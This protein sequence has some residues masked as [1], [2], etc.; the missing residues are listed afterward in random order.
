M[1]LGI[2]PAPVRKS[3]RIKAG[4]QKAFDVFTAGMGRWWPPSHSLLKAPR[5]DVVIEPR[6]GG[7]WY[8]RAVDGSE[9]NWGRVVSWEPPGRVL[10][11]WQLTGEWRFD[12][13][14][15]TALEILFLAEADG[16]TRIELEHRDIEKFG[17]AEEA[18]RR[19]LDSDGGWP[20]VL[21]AFAELVEQAA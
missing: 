6:A 8:E 10:L 17:E 2:K 9:C 1:T 11:A 4:Q 5:A 15:E 14:F 20:G 16:V 12:P 21:R 18:V 7:R 3:L 13:G 19:S